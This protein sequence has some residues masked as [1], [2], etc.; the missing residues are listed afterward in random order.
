[1]KR[2]LSFMLIVCLISFAFVSCS[3]DS[4][5]TTASGTTATAKSTASADEPVTIRFVSWQTNHAEANQ[6]VADAYHE[7]HPEVTVVFDY[8][9]DMNSNDYMTK[10]DI[11]IMGGEAMDIVMTPSFTA[12]ASRAASGAYLDLDPYFEAEGTSLEDSYDAVL[13]VNGG[14]YGIPGEMKYDMIL[15]NKDLLDEAGLDVPSLDWTWDDYRE[16]AKA[17]T[18]GEGASKI[19]G[20]FFYSWGNVNLYGVASAKKGNRYFNDDHT[21]VF[22][23]PSFTDFLQYRYDLENVDK[24]STPL[25]DIKSLNMNYRDQFFRGQIAM[26]PMGT[27]MLSDIGNEKYSPDFVTTFARIPSW[28]EDDP[29]YYITQ[30][31]VFSIS[32]TSEHPQE[33]YDFLRFWT[34]EGVAIK[35][36]FISN[37]KN[38]DRME[39]VNQIVAGFTDKLDIETLSAIMTDP[40]WESS[41]EEWVPEYQN[42]IDTILTEETDMFLLGSQSLDKTVQNLMKRGNAVIAEYEN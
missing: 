18:K 19:Y 24:C 26:L 33:A 6:A 11:M 8:I 16:Y 5:S 40:K 22:E 37:E 2:L 36:M 21:L 7:L 4:S 32:R 27:F 29:H 38:V 31:Q 13:R 1:M 15:I 20:S 34:T 35:G 9:G 17:L 25:A 42:E 14:A 3:K 39:S 10:T 12:F 23:D 41:Y 28:S 30:G